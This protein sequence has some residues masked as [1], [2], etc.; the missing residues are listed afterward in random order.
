MVHNFDFNLYG[1][2][3][4]NCFIHT[5]R[6]KNGNL[7]ISLFGTNPETNNT[8]HFVDITLEQKQIRLS[9]DRII[10]NSLYKPELIPQ[11]EELGILKEL[12]SRCVINGTIYPI[13]K[14]EYTKVYQCA[15]RMSE[16]AAVAA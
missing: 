16:L 5:S 3:F 9:D 6:Y 12:E 14:I 15:Y 7:Q 4:T 2:K 13:Y 10:V 1:L 11:L 8:E